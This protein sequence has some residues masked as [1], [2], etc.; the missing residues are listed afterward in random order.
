MVRTTHPSTSDLQRA[1]EELAGASAE[2]AR[3][4]RQR[5]SAADQRASSD[6]LRTVLLRALTC[7]DAAGQLVERNRLRT[8]IEEHVL[9]GLSCEGSWLPTTVRTSNREAT[10]PRIPGMTADAAP[11]FGAP[12]TRTYGLDL[13]RLLE[14]AAPV[15]P[16]DRPVRVAAPAVPAPRTAPR[17]P[18]PVS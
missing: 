13:T 6:A 7:A 17:E 9:S 1:R 4:V 12:A 5:L 10:G 15:A 8:R 11:P 3:A 14:P 18:V 2:H 16:A